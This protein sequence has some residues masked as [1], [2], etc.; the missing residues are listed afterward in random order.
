MNDD[1]RGK[2][3]IEQTKYFIIIIGVALYNQYC[4]NKGCKLISSY[5]DLILYSTIAK[6]DMNIPRVN[7]GWSLKM[8]SFNFNPLRINSHSSNRLVIF[9]IFSSLNICFDIK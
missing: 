7:S 1:M 2:I 8:L 6:M 3:A 9:N 5:T 4:C